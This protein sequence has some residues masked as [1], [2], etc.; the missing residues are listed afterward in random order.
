MTTTKPCPR[1]SKPIHN[2]GYRTGTLNT[3]MYDVKAGKMRP[4]REQF[5]TF[6]NYNTITWLSDYYDIT[7]G[8]DN[9]TNEHIFGYALKNIF[10]ELDMTDFPTTLPSFVTA[11]K[12]RNIILVYQYISDRRGHD[13]STLI[14]LLSNTSYIDVLIGIRTLL[15]NSMEINK[16]ILDKLP[17]TGLF[18]ETGFRRS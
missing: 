8:I 13:M 16:I 18:Q 4:T 7:V 5:G 3:T 15:K 2:T 14:G 1:C 10:H 17:T 9:I 6:E 11:C 12:A